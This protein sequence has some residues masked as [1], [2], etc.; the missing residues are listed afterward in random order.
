MSRNGKNGQQ[1]GA[2]A[3]LVTELSDQQRQCIGMMLQGMAQVDIA[4]E[5]DIAQETISR[6]KQSPSFLAVLNQG[7][8]DSYQAVTERL[9]SL[10]T[11]AVDVLAE[12][13]ASDHR[14][15]RVEAAKF[16][17]RAVDLADLPVDTRTDPTV[18]AADYAKE[19]QL[20]ALS[21]AMYG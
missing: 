21:M 16:I 18:I 4:C 13:L 7:R 6:W 11:K 14:P 3:D 10:A 8:L 2:G 19:Q 20:A 15:A 1:N 9:R 17:L 5:L 12:E